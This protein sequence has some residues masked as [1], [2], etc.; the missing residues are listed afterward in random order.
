MQ[1]FRVKRG[2][3]FIVTASKRVEYFQLEISHEVPDMNG[4]FSSVRFSK[5]SNPDIKLW[6]TGSQNLSPDK[7]YY[8]VLKVNDKK[9]CESHKVGAHWTNVR[10]FSLFLS[11][12]HV[13]ED[14]DAGPKG[15]GECEFY[16]YSGSK[17]LI[18]HGDYRKNWVS[19]GETINVNKHGILKD[20]GEGDVTLRIRGRECVE[21]ETIRIVGCQKSSI[22]K[23]RISMAIQ[24]MRP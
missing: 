16:V 18:K 9:G 10:S 2:L 4:D 21:M 13:Y 19:S 6:S 1:V 17:T 15:K 8:Y 24:L 12:I 7:L 11:K 14:G 3:K 20:I 22:R 23:P 5:K